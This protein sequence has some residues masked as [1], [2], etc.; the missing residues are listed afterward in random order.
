[1]KS[2]FNSALE[3]IKLATDLNLM[4]V[5]FEKFI[6]LGRGEKIKHEVL[7]AEEVHWL[8]KSIFNLFSL[9]FVNNMAR[10]K[11]LYVELN[12]K[13]KLKGAECV[14]GRYGACILPEGT[15]LPCRRFY[16][17]LGNLTKNEFIDIWL[18]SK[19]LKIVRDRKKLLGKCG[20]C[21]IRSCHGCRAMA[22]AMSGNFLG[23]DPSCWL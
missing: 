19:V 1:M 16:Y 7:S 15:L 22:M 8:Y 11:A 2:N 17:G 20:K 10:Y 3:M 13:P 9:K 12:S 14:V 23:E 4:G 21:R 18:N 6:P 5:I